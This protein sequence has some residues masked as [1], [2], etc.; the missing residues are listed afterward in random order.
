MRPMKRYDRRYFDRW[1]R[2]PDSPVATAGDLRRTVAMVVAI[3]EHMLGRSV[4]TVLDVGC[5]EGAWQ[6]ELKRLRPRVGY[7]G[8]DSSRYAVARFGSERNITS[9]RFEDLAALVE[10]RFDLIVCSDV[11]HYLSARDIDRGLP[12]LAGALDGVAYLPVHARED[13]PVGDLAGWYPRA[14]S[15]YL[16]RFRRNGLVP[17]GMQCYAGALLAESATALELA[18]C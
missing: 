14:A 2:D 4:R 9:G 13:E 12:H 5:G 1:Y 18:R 16:Q 7:E 11:L 8:I 6:P 17:C 3:T 15:W 10:R